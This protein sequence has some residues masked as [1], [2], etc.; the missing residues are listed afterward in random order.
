MAADMMDKD[1]MSLMVEDFI[2]SG[3]EE[4]ADVILDGEPYFD[5]KNGAWRQDAHDD[6]HSFMLFAYGGNIIIVPGGA[7]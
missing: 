3:G 4:L 7:L 6:D 1:M 2:F 5:E